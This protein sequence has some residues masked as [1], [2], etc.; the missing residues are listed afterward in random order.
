MADLFA[1]K[2]VLITGG[3]GSFGKAFLQYLMPNGCREI[4]IFSRDELKQEQMRVAF[5]NPRLKFY[6]GDVRDRAGVYDAMQDVDYVFHAAALKQV[7]SSEFF[8]MEAVKTNIIGSRNVVDAAIDRGIGRLVCLSTD[9]AVYPINAM[10]MTKALME[11]MVLSVA[12]RNP[13]SGTVLACV[14]Y[15]NVMASRG[16]VIPLFIRQIRNHTP[17]TVTVPE[18][19]RFLLPLPQGIELVAFAFR[20]CHQGDTFVRRAP[21]CTVGDLVTALKNLFHS[22]VPVRVIGMR[23]GEKMHET[24]ATRE[25]LARAQSLGEYY[26]IPM[27][28]RSLDYSDDFAE[29]SCFDSDLDDYTSHNTEQLDVAGVEQL[30]MTVPEVR[31]ELDAARHS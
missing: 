12:R 24:L 26:R 23:H 31:A 19:T 14:R 29:G 30:L 11:K 1:G 15:G 5:A 6:L 7:A 25:E 22:D 27:D 28:S 8:P 16:S 9:K 4:R 18:M 10:G 20:L 21:A 17:V 13:G 3:T 2:T